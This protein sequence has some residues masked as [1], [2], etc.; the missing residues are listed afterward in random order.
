MIEGYLQY[1]LIINIILVVVLFSIAV[2]LE[3]IKIQLDKFN[4]IFRKWGEKH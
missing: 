2:Q 1:F 4:K 3:G